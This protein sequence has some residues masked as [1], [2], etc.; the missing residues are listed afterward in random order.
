MLVVA[1]TNQSGV[2]TDLT[3]EMLGAA[4][5]LAQATGGQVV[6]LGLGTRIAS[7]AER[8]VGADRV[9][10]VEDESL[11]E[12]SPQSYLAT[13]ENLIDAESPR[14]VLIGS[15]SMGLDVA[16]AL[17][18]R[19]GAPVVGGCKAV[20]AD[21]DLLTVTA[22]LCAG[23]LLADVNVSVKPA[24]LLALPGSFRPVES[25]SPP[26]VESRP[27]PASVDG[28]Q[29]SFER[30][31]LPDASDVDITQPEVLICVGRGIGNQENL[32]IAE[33]LAGAI[34]GQ[35]CA[36]R[37][38]VDQGWL[39]ATR[40][41]GKSGMTVKPKCYFALG[42]S[43]APEHVEGMSDSE[44]IIAVNS[45][46]HAPILDVADYGIVGDLLDVVPVLCEAI[47]AKR[48]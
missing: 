48:A 13:L 21:G 30:L 5:S 2:V 47:Q 9:V 42:I 25:S 36:S 4:R 17:G 46:P 1:E 14:A 32:E 10:L 20:A 45:D 37:P 12:Y 24:I 11:T 18:T 7:Q 31:V 34:G 39:P 26:Q 16:P 15:T 29:V 8:L 22:S 23:K 19:L 28:A 38:I 43:G 6:A 35:L 44:L 27:S 33:E 3:L 41:V 40:Q